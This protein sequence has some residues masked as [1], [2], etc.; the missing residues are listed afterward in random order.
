MVSLLVAGQPGDQGAA[1][2]LR[3]AQRTRRTV[4]DPALD[5]GL[6]AFF[7]EILVAPL[8]PGQHL[9]HL[10]AAPSLCFEVLRWKLRRDYRAL[11]SID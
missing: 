2:G 10:L 11:R 9:G 7:G 3:N 8:E 6:A 4:P 5:A 1:K